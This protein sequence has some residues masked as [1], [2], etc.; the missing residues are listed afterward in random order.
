MKKQFLLAIIL[1]T[2]LLTSCSVFRSKSK[3]ITKKGDNKTKN[4][5]SLQKL[6]IFQTEWE[7]IKMGASKPNLTGTDNKVSILFSKDNSHFA[8]FSGCNRYSGKYEIKKT[9]L[10]FD[11]IISTKMACPETDM[12]FENN[13][14]N[15]LNKVD[16]FS[17]NGDTLFLKNNSRAVL[18]FIAK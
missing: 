11:N 9:S 12:S 1:F 6:D 16:N 8:G 7:L 4:E 18:I 13:Y 14:L 2:I 3:S 15:S 17:I 10:L 5:L